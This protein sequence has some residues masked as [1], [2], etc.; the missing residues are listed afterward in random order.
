MSLQLKIFQEKGRTG[1]EGEARHPRREKG[2]ES[3][4]GSGLIEE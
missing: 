4:V 2:L 3:F 1:L